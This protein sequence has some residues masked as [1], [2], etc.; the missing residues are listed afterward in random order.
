MMMET[1]QTKSCHVLEVVEEG[2][3]EW[4]C[5]CGVIR[6]GCVLRKKGAYCSS[7]AN[8]KSMMGVSPEREM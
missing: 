5:A 6:G 1:F 3:G 7:Q 2:G 8:G 4:G